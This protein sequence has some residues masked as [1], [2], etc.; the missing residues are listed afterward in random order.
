MLVL[1]RNVKETTVILVDG[2]KVTVTVIDTKGD[3]VRLAFDAPRDVRILREEV[4]LRGDDQNGV[5][6][7]AN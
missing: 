1:S 4:F 5:S 3:R 2:R 7:K 6:T